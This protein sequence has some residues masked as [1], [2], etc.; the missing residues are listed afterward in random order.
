[1]AL[2]VVLLRQWRDGDL[3]GFCEMNADP[4]V[5]RFFPKPLTPSESADMLA[6]LREGIERRGWGLWAVEADGRLAG[7]TGLAEPAFTSRFTPCVEIGWR[8]RREFWGRGIACRAACL[9]QSHAFDRLGLAELV[10][11]T[12][13]INLPSRRLMERLGFARDPGD[14]FDHPWLPEGHPLRPHVLYRKRRPAGAEPAPQLS[15]RKSVPRG[16]E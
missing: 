3:A 5:M 2:P 10:S 8:L 11:F 15:A 6:R 9:A 16:R 4:E 14:D 7:L 13:G 12:A 1:M